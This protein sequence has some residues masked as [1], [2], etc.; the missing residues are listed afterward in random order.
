[1]MMFFSIVQTQSY[2]I[3]FVIILRLSI[4]TQRTKKVPKCTINSVIDFE[5][6]QKNNHCHCYKGPIKHGL[7]KQ[8]NHVYGFAKYVYEA[9][10]NIIYHFFFKKKEQVFNYQIFLLGLLP[11]HYNGTK[12]S[13]W[14]S[15]EAVEKIYS[16]NSLF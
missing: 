7:K 5:T 9:M 2:F 11:S 1:M 10:S 4:N 13:L 14:T 3:A 16:L 12:F 6:K 15:D 8:T